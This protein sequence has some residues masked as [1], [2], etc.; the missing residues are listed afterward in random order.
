MKINKLEVIV[1]SEDFKHGKH[2]NPRAIKRTVEWS[3]ARG[4]KNRV[5]YG[6]DR[7]PGRRGPITEGWGKLQ[8]CMEW[9]QSIT[10]TPQYEGFIEIG[11]QLGLISLQQRARYL[12][13][14]ATA[15]AAQRTL[16]GPIAPTENQNEEVRKYC[17]KLSEIE[18]SNELP[19]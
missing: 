17:A 11:F 13:N 3:N 16:N 1:E 10:F 8:Q 2:V 9:N 7:L 5:K 4:E 14:K 6:Y 12:Q 15:M 19:K 18:Y